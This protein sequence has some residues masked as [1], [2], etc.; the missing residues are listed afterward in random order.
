M[1]IKLVITRIAKG[2]YRVISPDRPIICFTN[3]GD[4]VLCRGLN[5]QLTTCNLNY[6]KQASRN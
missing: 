4:D 5:L 3:S 2:N 6:T 1:Q